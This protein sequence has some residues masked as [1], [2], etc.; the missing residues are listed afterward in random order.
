MVATRDPHFFHPEIEV[1]RDLEAFLKQD[2]SEELF[3]IGGA[4]IYRAALPT[5][6]AYTSLTLRKNMRGTCIFPKSISAATGSLTRRKATNSHF[7]YTRGSNHASALCFHLRSHRD[8]ALHI[9]LPPSPGQIF[10]VEH[11]RRFCRELGRDLPSLCSLLGFHRRPA[12]EEDEGNKTESDLSLFHLPCR[13]FSEMAIQHPGR[14]RKQRSAS[15]GW[16]IPP[17]FE[18]PINAR[19]NRDHLLHEGL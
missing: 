14:F 12:F 7:A 19:S 3:V 18:S 2:F 5:R 11:S 13:G 10:L 16:E 6:S 1:I 17:G 15:E 4:E 9:F 8:C